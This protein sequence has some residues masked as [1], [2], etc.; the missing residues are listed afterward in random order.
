M[1]LNIQEMMFLNPTDGEPMDNGQI[2]QYFLSNYDGNAP[3]WQL[4]LTF[5]SNAIS[6]P[7]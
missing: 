4:P 1:T 6:K 3:V 7:D 5:L 2:V